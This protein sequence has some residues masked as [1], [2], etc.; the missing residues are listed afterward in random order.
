MKIDVNVK[1]PADAI[2]KKLDSIA[3]LS[4]GD[5][6]AL[7][8]L[9]LT[10]A[11]VSRDSDIL[12]EGDRPQRSLIVLDGLV[13]R[14]R[15]LS[16]GGRQITSFHPPGDMPDLQ[17]LFLHRMD[18][19]IAPLCASKIAF[20]EH[21]DLRQLIDNRPGLCATLWRDTLID[22][23]IYREWLVGLGRRRA[24]QRVAHLMCEMGS[25]LKAVGLFRNQSFGLPLTQTEL[26]DAAG[27]SPVHLN[28]VLRDLRSWNLVRF[29]DY[30]V[31]SP[32]WLATKQLAGFD[33][34]Y[35]HQKPGRA[36]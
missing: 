1:S 9:P 17:S 11:E 12:A 27:L 8:A 19:S 4:D 29:Q 24:H 36:I 23:A 3:V 6:A 16:D 25:R 35:L 21:R 13:C 26:A 18:H 28:R 33:S 30:V 34:A 5:Q 14:Y 31:S 32:D 2:L 7:R 15:M 20:V 10:V 22:A